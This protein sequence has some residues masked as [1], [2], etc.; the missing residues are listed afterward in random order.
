MS[1]VPNPAPSDA[2]GEPL[3]STVTHYGHA[4][5]KN[6]PIT[7]ELAPF[8][9]QVLKIDPI[10]DVPGNVQ[11]GQQKRP[12]LALKIDALHPDEQAEVRRKMELRPNMP[13]AERAKLEAQLVAEVA[14]GKLGAVRAMTGLGPDALPYHREAAEL[15]GQVA[16]L[17]RQRD[18]LQASIDDIADVRP[19]RDETT[20]EVIAIPVY[21]LSEERRQ[22]YA[23]QVAE[24]DRNIRLLVNPDGSYGIEGQKRMREALAVSAV[25]LKR[26]QEL[27]ADE[28]EA[29]KRAAEMA[30]EDRINKRAEQLAKMRPSDS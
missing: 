25:Q 22:A 23:N 2:S 14:R 26:A 8:A 18:A 17:Q 29:Q 9:E 5:H 15:A 11:L 7:P 3:R 1:Q 16:Q 20:G 13:P 30:R 28:A 6:D 10:R 24:Y 12:A 19:G 4:T 21:R 27:R